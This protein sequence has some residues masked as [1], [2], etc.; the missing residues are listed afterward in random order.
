MGADEYLCN[1]RAEAGWV[2]MG[3]VEPRTAAAWPRAGSLLEQADLNQREGGAFLRP[4]PSPQAFVCAL[5]VL[6][7]GC[8]PGVKDGEPD[9]KDTVPKV[10]STTPADGAVDVEPG[11]V[12]V[13]VFDQGMDAASLTADSFRVEG[14]AGSV[15]YDDATRAATF[16]PAA[17]LAPG[18]TVHA[19]LSSAIQSAAGVPIAQEVSF[20]FTVTDTAT[21]KI[22]STQPAQGAVDVPAAAV[23]SATFNQELSESS[24][25]AHSFSIRTDGGEPLPGAVGYDAERRTLTF[26][27]TPALPFDTQ[28][29]ARVDGVKAQN[30]A[31]LTSAYEWSF[32][33]G[34]DR[35]GPRVLLTYPADGAVDV[36]P[37][38]PV[39]VRFDEALESA[40]ITAT[41][42]LVS[43]V[44]GATEWREDTR[45]ITFMPEAPF[46]AG[47]VYE[48]E[49][50]PGITDL[51]GN[52]LKEPFR[53][54]FT[55]GADT[56][57][58]FVVST[59]LA[60]GDFE[61][62]NGPHGISVTFSEPISPVSF[63]GNLSIKSTSGT[64]V[65]M[66][67]SYEP[68]T[69]TSTLSVD[70]N[71]YYPLRLGT[72][73]EVTLTS[74]IKDLAGNGLVA[75]SF[76]FTVV[77]TRGP[78]VIDY[79]PR[80]GARFT[81]TATRPTISF[82]E[83]I[84][85]D[86]V[87]D[88]IAVT[89][90]Q[91]TLMCWSN[92]VE[93]TPT[94]P[95]ARGTTYQ[96]TVGPGVK[97][98][99]GHALLQPFGFSFKTLEAPTTLSADTRS[100]PENPVLAYA[101]N[102]DGMAAWV[103]STGE[104][105]IVV[106]SRY[107][108]A[109]DTWEPPAALGRGYEVHLVAGA[110]GE[111]AAVADT[112]SDISLRVYSGGSWSGPPPL[113]YARNPRLAANDDGFLFAYETSGHRLL[114]WSAGA[115]DAELAL[116]DTTSYPEVIL[117]GR[118]PDFFVFRGGPQLSV[119][120][121]GGATLGAE[122]VL[123]TAP[124]QY[125]VQVEGVVS[126]PA[127][128]ALAYQQAS[129]YTLNPSTS[130]VRI[131]S[132]GSWGAQKALLS[133][134]GSHKVLI[135]SNGSDEVLLATR[136]FYSQSA[137]A[138]AWHYAFSTNLWSAEELATP[139]FGGG[140]GNLAGGPAGFALTWSSGEAWVAQR[141][142]AGWGTPHAWHPSHVGENAHFI[143]PRP[144][145]F[146][147]AFLGGGEVLAVESSG[148]VFGQPASL[149]ASADPAS[150]LHGARNAQ[151]LPALAFSQSGQ[152]HTRVLDGTAPV[153]PLPTG[154]PGSARNVRLALA[155][156]G[157]AVV[158]WEQQD[159]GIFG[160]YASRYD[161]SAWSVPQ[162][163]TAEGSTAAVATDGSDFVLAYRSGGGVVTR[164]W[165]AAGLGAED[166]VDAAAGATGAWRSTPAGRTGCSPSRHLPAPAGTSAPTRR[167]GGCQPSSAARPRPRASASP[168]TVRASASSAIC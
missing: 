64:Q 27:P 168:P 6:A 131:H 76:T 25:T 17:P 33:T 92:K 154:V 26:T 89:G 90:V 165:S 117:L 121:L 132:G 57:A 126:T 60:G 88:E 41:T 66:S 81:G 46:T 123:A 167:A 61:W 94:A 147:I 128:I 4:C 34:P 35:E 2:W 55:A 28:V 16:Q 74:G 48:V 100:L 32:T 29:V 19:R 162:R 83:P 43:G 135:A 140:L 102:G 63:S 149:E 54:S 39:M 72:T 18:S 65:W 139:A 40:S 142:S 148:G 80:P 127:G 155:Q 93:L 21:L 125:E 91:T 23:V 85:C 42:F 50:T 22:V 143:F 114:R 49:L 30:G 129:A 24:I 111:F 70:P 156:S 78:S 96:V 120:V 51:A 68:T 58:P 136:V 116:P 109:T 45:T 108:A 8:G 122:T 69:M 115:W 105:S 158:V 37:N 31:A 146:L 9:P 145:G 159:V 97:D 95:L 166:T 98:P 59:S 113:E 75:H 134:G 112:S 130:Y 153:R 124:A 38:A 150:S 3:T 73:Y 62:T 106:A 160:V 84:D 157:H 104:S 12:I 151:G 13:A 99:A 79:S 137:A 103:E 86:T 87:Q 138:S 15:T 110:N 152:V 7:F 67:S 20:S 164:L 1:V 144:A 53:F 101:A 161:G 36:H 163:L 47:T 77:D 14:V 56:T 52:P 44:A 119:W 133:T 11:A 71:G 10:V 5:V 107:D 82:D 118:G 141:T